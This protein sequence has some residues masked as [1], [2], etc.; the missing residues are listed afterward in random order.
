MQFS[1]TSSWIRIFALV[2]ALVMPSSAALA[3]ATWTVTATTGD[4]SPLNAV[5]LGT[6]LILDIKLETSAPLEMIATAGSVNNYD[7]AIVSLVAGQTVP[8]DL[9]YEVIIPGA[10]SFNGITNLES[11]VVDTSEQG[12]GQEDTFLS[13]LATSGT[14]GD[15]TAEAA[16]F[17]IVYNVI[18]NGTTTLRVGTFADYADAYSGASD[19][20]VN[21]AEVTIT[22]GGPGPPPPPP[23]P[24]AAPT[25]DV[26]ASAEFAANLF[27]ASTT[28]ITNPLPITLDVPDPFDIGNAL[29]GRTEAFDLELQLSAGRF[30]L[31][32]TISLP[33]NGGDL[34][35][36]PALGAG[37]SN[38]WQISGVNFNASTDSLT[39]SLAPGAG[40]A[41]VG[42]GQILFIDA[43]SLVV[44][45]LDQALGTPGGELSLTVSSFDGSEALITWISRI[46]TSAEGVNLIASPTSVEA[47]GMSDSNGD[48][49]FLSNPM[50][51]GISGACHGFPDGGLFI[52]AE[53]CSST[54]TFQFNP[55]EDRIFV[56]VVGSG[57]AELQSSPHSRVSIHAEGGGCEPYSELAS[58]ETLQPDGY[59][60][61]AFLDFRPP[62]AEDPTFT[63]CLRKGDGAPAIAQDLQIFVS[64]EFGS[65]FLK[66]SPEDQVEFSI[67]P[68]CY[69]DF[70]DDGR[71]NNLDALEFRSCF[72]CSGPSC[73]R[74]CDY[75]LDG[76]ISNVDALAFRQAFGKV[77]ADPNFAMTSPTI[78]TL[79]RTFGE[80]SSKWTM[81]TASIPS[82]GALLWCAVPRRRRS[83]EIKLVN[84]G[85]ETGEQPESEPRPVL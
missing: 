4:G 9:L 40:S 1:S 35:M 22:V 54:N 45:E 33:G 84:T 63:V 67:V 27:G 70:N 78:E 42:I 62:T 16:Q 30:L 29:V 15:G 20:I 57:L 56:R 32:P 58:T 19:N 79:T 26:P 59:S 60:E 82:F 85:T 48:L 69:G 13:T 10:G 25:I 76:R 31:E 38:P 47:T 5:N 46:A 49:I 34:I 72:G 14:G 61:S 3:S 6:T 68:R 41:P 83:S 51:V 64:A 23:P 65:A 55:I 44:E 80:P 75:D 11:T 50:T 12:P 36:G 7:T 43:E 74:A 37:G 71:V 17:T 39:I 73:N 52:P 81:L 28:A 18:G 77:C 66:P 2:S 21:N 53:N 8:Y 24:T